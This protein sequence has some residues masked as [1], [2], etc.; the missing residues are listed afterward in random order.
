MSWIKNS[1]IVSLLNLN[2][3]PKRV[4]TSTKLANAPV[5]YVELNNSSA[6][7]TLTIDKPKAGWFLV[8]TQIDSGT[9]GHS[10]NLT[11]GTYDGTN[12]KATLNSQYETIVLFG[13]SATRFVIVENIGAVGL[14]T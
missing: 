7:I 2:L 1:G 8:I 14:T 9:A 4:T 6:G 12:T 10:A 5:S 3:K 13:V 11:A